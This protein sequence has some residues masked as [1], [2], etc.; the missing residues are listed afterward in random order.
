MPDLRT[1]EHAA[2]YNIFAAAP[3]YEERGREC[4]PSAYGDCHRSPAEMNG[5]SEVTVPTTKVM[6]K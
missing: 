6:A 4:A 5:R 1:S 2:R 3:R